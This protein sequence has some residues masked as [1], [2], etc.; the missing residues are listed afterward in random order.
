MYGTPRASLVRLGQGA[1]AW[2]RGVDR[3]GIRERVSRPDVWRRVDRPGADGGGGLYIV[4]EGGEPA[5]RLW[6]LSC[7]TQDTTD[8]MGRTQL[9]NKL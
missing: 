3:G 4:K 5:L 9:T 7:L 8:A 2:A 6:A 1:G